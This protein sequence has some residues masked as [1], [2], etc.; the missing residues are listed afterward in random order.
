MTVEGRVESLVYSHRGDGDAI[1]SQG[2]L[3]HMRLRAEQ[4]GGRLGVMEI[5]MPSGFGVPLHRHTREDEL[6]HVL[7][8]EATFECGGE[9]ATVSRGGFV[10][11]PREVPHRFKVG[12]TPMRC[13]QTVVPGGLERFFAE[14][15]VPA[16]TDELPGTGV[17][18]AKLKETTPKYGIEILGPPLP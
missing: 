7:D 14:M 16:T 11:L 10:L 8:G 17:D 1:W 13:L 9:L 5:L 18:I 4:A 15:G 3:I 6:F 2:M 12:S